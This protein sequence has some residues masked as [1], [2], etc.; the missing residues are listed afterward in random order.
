M[1]SSLNLVQ[2]SS[3]DLVSS[4][5]GACSLTCSAM[6]SNLLVCPKTAQSKSALVTRYGSMSEAGLLSSYYPFPSIP[7]ILGTLMDAP[8]L[9]MPQLKSEMEEVSCAPESLS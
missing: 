9:A 8:R 6:S 1:L 4:I 2:C 3:F 7:V 5:Y